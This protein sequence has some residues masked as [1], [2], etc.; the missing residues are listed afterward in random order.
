MTVTTESG[1]EKR[2]HA[3]PGKVKKVRGRR[4]VKLLERSGAWR[5]VD[6]AAITAVAEAF[7]VNK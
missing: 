4:Q 1:I 6:L 3:L 2:I 7:G 5:V